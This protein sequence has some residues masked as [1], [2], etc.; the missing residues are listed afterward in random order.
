MHIY[1][2]HYYQDNC[3]EEGDL[4]E[5][6]ST[7]GSSHCG[8][9]HDEKWIEFLHLALDEWIEKAKEHGKHFGDDDSIHIRVCSQHE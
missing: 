6:L 4:P 8:S 7:V 9:I 3:E 2:S 5:F 1:I